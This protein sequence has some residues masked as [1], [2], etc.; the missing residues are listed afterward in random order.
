M[1]SVPQ[2]VD[3]S[4][5][6]Y[7]RTVTLFWLSAQSGTWPAYLGRERGRICRN[8]AHQLLFYLSANVRHKT[9]VCSRVGAP[10]S[11][12]KLAL[13]LIILYFPNLRSRF[14]VPQMTWISAF[15]DWISSENFT[16]SCLDKF[17][18]AFTSRLTLQN[19]TGLCNILWSKASGAWSPSYSAR[20]FAERNTTKRRVRLKRSVAF[21]KT[22]R[23]NSLT[24]P[25]CEMAGPFSSVAEK[26]AHEMA[27]N[28]ATS[29]DITAKSAP[30]SV[31]HTPTHHSS[32]AISS[33]I[34]MNLINAGRTTNKPESPTNY[35]RPA[36]SHISFGKLNFLITH[37][38]TEATLETY[39]SVSI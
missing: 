11:V 2:S 15:V 29:L 35:F 27:A 22:I 23:I 14:C 34:T 28:R 1:F 13:R 25:H 36:H 26:R 12:A 6:E 9:R 17:T 20:R 38:P 5:C 37:Q 10:L 18:Y 24:D 32:D 33:A 4:C 39:I 21:G 16:S 30:N 31:T 19:S 3:Y 8:W 7:L